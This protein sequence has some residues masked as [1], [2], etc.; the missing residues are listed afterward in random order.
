MEIK[1]PKVGLKI[2]SLYWLLSVALGG[3]ILYLLSRK[4]ITLIKLS[5]TAIDYAR[6]QIGVKEI[7]HNAGKQV[8]EYQASTGNVSGAAWCMSFVYWCFQKAAKDRNMVNP[9]IRTGGVL[10]QWNRIPKQYKYAAP[11]VG[12]IFI[13]STG[14]GYGHTGIITKINDNGTFT[15]IEGNSNRNGSREGIE[16]CQNTRKISNSAILGYITI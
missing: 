11:S 10:D 2:S 16:V 15:A 5:D 8:N 1:L 13:M 7:G 12:S 4:H 6:S 14:G 3:L 9:L